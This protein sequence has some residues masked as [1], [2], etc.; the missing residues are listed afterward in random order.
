MLVAV[1]VLS[2][3]SGNGSG[4]ASPSAAASA[5][6]SRQARSAA[7]SSPRS[8]AVPMNTSPWRGSTGSSPA[9]SSGE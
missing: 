5:P 6:V 4:R 9:R 3:Y 7:S 1:R 8:R 2:A